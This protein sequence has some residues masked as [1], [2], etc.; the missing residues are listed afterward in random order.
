MCP[1]WL[2]FV[3]NVLSSA[4]TE[5]ACLGDIWVVFGAEG[6]K[7][8]SRGVYESCRLTACQAWGSVLENNVEFAAGRGHSRLKIF[9]SW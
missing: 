7:T 5:N 2:C 4:W 3:L 1:R 9:L 8:G 6:L